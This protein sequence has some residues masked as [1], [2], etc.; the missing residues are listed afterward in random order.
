MRAVVHP[1]RGAIRLTS[2]LYALSDPIRLD[3]V[4]QL[5]GHNEKPCG[6]FVSLPK[7]SLSHHFKVLREAGVTRTKLVG[8]NR[9]T[10]LRREDLEAR[11][12][13]LIDSVLEAHDPL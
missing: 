5:N 4:R 7:S 8:R 1:E 3:I 11:F 10:S 12:P 2:V 6:D 9:F 13:G